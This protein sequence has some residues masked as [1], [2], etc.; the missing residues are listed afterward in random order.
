MVDVGVIGVRVRV[1]AIGVS[2][3]VIRVI[4]QLGSLGFGFALTTGY[5]QFQRPRP[6]AIQSGGRGI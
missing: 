5:L 1:R 2:V 3:G 6:G 4:V